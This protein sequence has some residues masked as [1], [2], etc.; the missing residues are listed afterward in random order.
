MLAFSPW[1]L[2][3]MIKGKKMIDQH[4]D[5]VSFAA[6]NFFGRHGFLT[7]WVEKTGKNEVC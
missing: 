1:L 2:G 7:T 5:V 6:L 3:L 4:L